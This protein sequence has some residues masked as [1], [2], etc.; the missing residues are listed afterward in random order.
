MNLCVA[1]LLVGQLMAPEKEAA[2]RSYI[3]RVTDVSVLNEKLAQAL[4]YTSEELPPLMQ[5]QPIR[6]G[7]GTQYTTWM[8]VFNDIGPPPLPSNMN[9]EFPWAVDVPAGTQDCP[10]HLLYHFAGLWLPGQS[11]GNPWPVVAWRGRLREKSTS[12]NMPLPTKGYRW[13]YPVEAISFENLMKQFSDG[14]WATYELRLRLYEKDGQSFER[15]CP[16]IQWPAFASVST[17]TLRDT[18]HRREHAFESTA[19]EHVLPRVTGACDTLLAAKFI[20]VLDGTQYITP[21][22]LDDDNYVPRNYKA[23]FIKDCMDCHRDTLRSASA[24][25]DRDWYDFGVGDHFNRKF[26]PVNERGEL[27]PE[28]E[29]A[30][31]VAWYD[32]AKHTPE[33]YGEIEP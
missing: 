11:N 10:K 22:A 12:V 8:S 13:R 25:E 28:L 29:A 16:D 9:R 33:I 4:L 1:V 21:T 24:F 30:G 20:P 26:R 32:P 23:Y 19:T 31:L 7:R 27:I 15:Y 2:C 6:G 17:K 5:H 3:P 14:R 18:R